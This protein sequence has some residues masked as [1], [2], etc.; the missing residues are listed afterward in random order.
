MMATLEYLAKAQLLGPVVQA[1]AAI[2]AISGV[3]WTVLNTRRNQVSKQA[4]D[5]YEAY[6]KDAMANPKLATGIVA[7]PASYAAAG[8]ASEFFK[9]EWLVARM[10]TAGE[11]ILEYQPS[12]AAWHMTIENQIKAHKAYFASRYFGN[13]EFCMYSAE[14]QALICKAVGPEECAKLRANP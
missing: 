2:V 3:L 12:D 10:L 5:A 4:H 7:I 9:Y 1:I 8:D 14:I 11:Q 13:T 6:L